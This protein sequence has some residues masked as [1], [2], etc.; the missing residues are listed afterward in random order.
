MSGGDRN[1][2]VPQRRHGR[3]EPEM[4][5]DRA[6]KLFPQRVQGTAVLN[7]LG[8]KPDVEPLEYRLRTIVLSVYLRPRP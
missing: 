1:A 5:V 7:S 2:G 4:R 6:A 3:V 8:P